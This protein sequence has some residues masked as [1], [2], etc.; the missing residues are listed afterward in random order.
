MDGSEAKPVI[1]SGFTAFGVELSL[2]SDS[3]KGIEDH[4]SFRKPVK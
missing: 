4:E 3:I 1:L 2:L